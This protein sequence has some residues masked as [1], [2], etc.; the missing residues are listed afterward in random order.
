MRQVRQGICRDTVTPGSAGR[1]LLDWLARMAGVQCEAAHAKRQ[2]AQGS[3][4]VLEEQYPTCVPQQAGRAR[5][6]P[7]EMPSRG[8]LESSSM[9]GTARAGNAPRHTRLKATGVVSPCAP[10]LHPQSQHGY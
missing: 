6:A 8:H 2:V 7:S 10:R 5:A 3:V 1:G 4:C 9:H